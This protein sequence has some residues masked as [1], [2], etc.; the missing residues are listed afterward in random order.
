VRKALSRDG[1]V[2]FSFTR[3][4]L[5]R[6]QKGNTIMILKIKDYMKS[7]NQSVLLDVWNYFDNI[8]SASNFYHEGSKETVVRCTFRDGNTITFDILYEAYL[9]SDTGKTIERIFA[10]KKEPDGETE[11]FENLQDAIDHAMNA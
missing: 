3:Q 10:A 8:T 4:I 9:M 11:R 2:L 5:D 6:R 1:W 7:E